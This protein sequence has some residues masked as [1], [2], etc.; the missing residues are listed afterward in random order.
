M[1]TQAENE[2]LTRVG[3][4]TPAGNL[5]LFI[6]GGGRPGLVADRCA[7]FVRASESRPRPSPAR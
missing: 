6:D 2:R 5:M 1:L 4:G 3:S 7:H